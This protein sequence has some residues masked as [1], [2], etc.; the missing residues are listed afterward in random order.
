MSATVKRA[1]AF[2]A[3]F[4]LRVP[5]RSLPWPAQVRHLFSSGRALR[6]PCSSV[7]GTESTTIPP[8][9]MDHLGGPFA[10]RLME[11]A[12]ERTVCGHDLMAL[13]AD[14]RPFRGSTRRRNPRGRP[15]KRGRPL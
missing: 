10:F 11:R 7:A 5:T 12:P 8:G 4:G 14:S 1:D 15:C 3:R 2:C 6:A 13:E 9:L